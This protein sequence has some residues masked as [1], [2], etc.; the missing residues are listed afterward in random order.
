MAQ[1]PVRLQAVA[2]V[3][4]GKRRRAYE[5]QPSRLLQRFGLVLGLLAVATQRLLLLWRFPSR[6]KSCSSQTATLVADQEATE[7]QHCCCCRRRR[8]RRHCSRYSHQCCSAWQ[9]PAVALSTPSLCGCAVAFRLVSQHYRCWRATA[10]GFRALDRCN[11][12]QAA[13]QHTLK[14]PLLSQ[15]LRSAEASILLC[16]A[17]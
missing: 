8:R 1:D 6:A 12:Q 9:H 2:L 14:T 11:Q 7:N 16:R 13:T 10:S 4:L 5:P 17:R 15:A 3:P